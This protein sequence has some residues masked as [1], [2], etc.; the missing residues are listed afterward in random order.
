MSIFPKKLHQTLSILLGGI[1][2]VVMIVVAN[3]VTALSDNELYGYVCNM[4]T[5]Q[6]NPNY[7]G[8]II[9]CISLSHVSATPEYATN[10][11]HQVFFTRS[12]PTA[13]TPTLGEFSGTGFNPRIG[14]VLFGQTCPN[15]PGF[16]AAMQTGKQCAKLLD[17]GGTT[18]AADSINTGWGKFIYVG[19]IT[20][21]LGS[22]KLAGIGWQSYNTDNINVVSDVGIG[23]LDFSTAFWTKLG[24]TQPSATNRDPNATVD[25]NSCSFPSTCGGAQGVVYSA[26]NSI[27]GTGIGS[28]DLCGVNNTQVSSSFSTSNPMSSIGTFNWSCQS[29]TPLVAPVSCSATWNTSVTAGG[30]SCGTANGGAY[31]AGTNLASTSPNLCAAG[32][33]IVSGSFGTTPIVSP[34]GSFS[35]SCQSVASPLSSPASCSAN[36]S[37][38][39]SPTGGVGS[40]TPSKPVN[41]GFR[42]T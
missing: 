42:E 34:M 8:N 7:S 29:I 6:T 23:K 9:G 33:T 11:T 39:G 20:H 28:I 16:T 2:L 12:S 31:L 30:S 32:N 13:T 5:G 14:E 24:C 27:S 18:T 25:D 37:P 10:T 41:P 38:T 35:W 40:G 4:L 26:S 17:V 15:E 36:W 1:A 3:N 22:E 21:T 19:N